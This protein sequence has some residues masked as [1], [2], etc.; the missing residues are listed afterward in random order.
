M[1]IIDSKIDLNSQGFAARYEAMKLM[2]EELNRHL[3]LAKIEGSDKQI[4][5]H[6][7]ANKMLAR[8]RVKRLLDPQSPFFELMPLAGWGQ[9][10]MSLGGSIVGGIGYINQKPVVINANV[11]T[12]KGGALNYV[13]VLKSQRL[14]VIAKENR[15]PTIY[16]CESAGAHLPQQALVYNLGGACFREIARRSKLGIPNIAVVF[17]SSTAGGAYIPG[18]SDYI[19]M[20]KKQAK[21]FLA[22]PP[23]VKMAIK[24]EIDDESL[25]GA[26]M[27]SRISG[28][29]DFLAD[30][31]DQALEKAREI[32]GHL[33]T[34]SSLIYSQFEEPRYSGDEILGIVSKDVRSVF[35]PREIIARIVDGS[36]FTEFKPEYGPTLVCGFAKIFGH[37]IGI[38]SNRGI[39]VS[40]ASNKG[41]QFIQLCNQDGR[42]I[43]FLQNITGFMV[44]KKVEQD[45]I[46]KHGAKMINAVANSEVPAITIMMGAS[47]GAGNY[48]MCGRAFEPRFLFSWPHSKLAVM[49]GEQLAGVLEIVKRQSSAKEG[50]PV[51]EAELE[52]AKSILLEQ[53]EQ[54]SSAYYASSRIWDDGIID[55]RDTRKVV[56]QCLQIIGYQPE[57][58][59]HNQSYGIF[60]M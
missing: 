55:P 29:S 9:S 4:K 21:V 25:G 11:P 58:N 34:R 56:G 13:S 50:L 49:G 33:N 3:D 14:D 26:E 43:L 28:V 40:E 6:L 22:G 37:K 59:G 54:E 51:N 41:A 20:V 57:K 48:A 15:L 2:V 19:I 23:L 10:D 52:H 38:L 16:L 30:S 1:A 24:E 27:H 39:L 8:Q 45:G 32:L 42:P 60:R 47:Y 12:L 5:R 35:D 7:E 18:M 36:D 44:G 17:G 46:I 53:I 31:E